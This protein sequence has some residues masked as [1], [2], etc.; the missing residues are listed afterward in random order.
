[1]G[2]GELAGSVGIGTA[3]WRRAIPGRGPV[4]V[5]GPGTPTA[6]SAGT[7]GSSSTSPSA[8]SSASTGVGPPVCLPRPRP[9]APGPTGPAW[10]C[11]GNGAVGEAVTDGG[12]D[13]RDGRCG[14]LP[15]GCARRKTTTQRPT[16]AT[17]STSKADRRT[18][19]I[20]MLAD[21]ATVSLAPLGPGQRHAWM[22]RGGSTLGLGIGTMTAAP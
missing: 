5:I 2:I 3:E 22:S 1:L 7:A 4:R 10:S 20:L 6:G 15:A 8:M 14:A 21:F 17:Q 19:W 18:L 9:V 12:E 11:P 16:A 13:P